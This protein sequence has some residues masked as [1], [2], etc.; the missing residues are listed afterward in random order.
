LHTR[1]EQLLVRAA[2]LQQRLTEH[3]ARQ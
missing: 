3:G 1:T 2:R